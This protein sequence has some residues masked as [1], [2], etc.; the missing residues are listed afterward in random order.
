MNLKL[1]HLRNIALAAVLAPAVGGSSLVMADSIDAFNNS[2]V[3]QTLDLQRGLDNNAPIINNNILGT[4][5]SYNSDVYTACNF[6]VGCRYLD[7]QQKYSIKDQL[8]MG[9][10]FVELDVH[11]TTKMESLFSYP[12]RLLLC[13]GVCSINDKYATEG[14]NEIK[15]WLNDSANA[16]EV[17]ILYIED[18]SD[19]HHSDLYNQLNSAFG[20]KIYAS[21]GCG[22]I[23]D[24]LTKADVLASG[25]Q[26]ILWKDG[27]CSGNGSMASTAF[28]GLGNVGRIWEDGTT[29]GTIAEFFSGGVDSITASEV[30]EAFATGANIVNLD[31]MVM[32][33]GRIQAAIWSW[34][35]DEPNDAGGNEDC[36]TQTS[37]ARWNDVNCGNTYAFACKDANNNWSVPY[38]TS[39]TWSEGASAC[40]N[41]GG[42]YSFSVPTNSQANQALKTAKEASGYNTVWLNHS[43][44]ATEGNWAGVQLSVVTGV[45]NISFKSAH[46]KYLVAEN[47]GN[48]NVNAD[49][50]AV[51]SW[52]TFDI[53]LLSSGSCVVNGSNIAVNTQAGYY[54]RATSGGGLDANASAIG[55]WEQFSLVNHSDSSG[56][57]ANGDS[58]SLKSAHNKYVVAESNG[59][60]NADRSA[61]GSWERFVVQF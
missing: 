21:G 54:L 5:N 43:D 8:R 6:S 31:D 4:H 19:N 61:I 34:N 16:D 44:A 13:H 17:I 40:A 3:G 11:W 38:S 18:H 48:S 15:D 50:S 10:R 32:D 41:L 57:L 35:T 12:K 37:S 47:N 23:P 33:D 7:P 51:G 22:D 36:A 42:S 58:I 14:F 59:D 25:K 24:S 1:T 26:V 2:W 29:L 9:A 39:G 52:E 27:G 28:T 60:A 30:S 20:S 56:C 53:E 46:N 45:E 49:R 55:S